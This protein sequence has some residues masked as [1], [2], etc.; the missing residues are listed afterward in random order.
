MKKTLRRALACMIVLGAF[1]LT[2]TALF[3]G[4]VNTVK[5]AVLRD[6]PSFLGKAVETLGSG[7]AIT[8]MSEEGAWARV[9]AGGKQGWLPVSAL[10]AGTVSLG[11][12]SSRASV[13]AGSS[14]VA[15]AGK[16]FTQ[17]TEASY[18]ASQSGLDYATVDMMAGFVVPSA[19][20]EQFLRTGREGGAR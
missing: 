5:E 15:L 18:R 12:G 2:A 1:L 13:S 8:L 14:E 3:A 9:K 19:D 17:Q 6:S 20:S 11:A 7:T 10:R 16:G 4:V